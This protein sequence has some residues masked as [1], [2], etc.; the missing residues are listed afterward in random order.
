[1]SDDKFAIQSIG[2]GEYLGDD[3][4]RPGFGKMVRNPDEAR[5]YNTREEAQAIVDRTPSYIG[6]V[7]A[8]LPTHGAGK[9]G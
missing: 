2:T 6:Y 8:R 5:A 4:H 1:M 7:V 9:C 3:E